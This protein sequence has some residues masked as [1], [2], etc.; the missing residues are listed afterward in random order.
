MF[1]PPDLYTEGLNGR[2]RVYKPISPSNKNPSS[3]FLL[4]MLIDCDSRESFRT[5]LHISCLKKL[6]ACIEM[7]TQHMFMHAYENIAEFV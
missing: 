5:H 7:A 3:L 6:F 4:G 2:S 1:Y